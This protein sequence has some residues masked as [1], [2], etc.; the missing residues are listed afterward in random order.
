MVSIHAHGAYSFMRRCTLSCLV[1][2]ANFAIEVTDTGNAFS[3]DALYY[4]VRM[5]VLCVTEMM[6]A[7]L[8]TS[9]TNA[10]RRTGSLNPSHTPAEPK[11]YWICIGFKSHQRSPDKVCAGHNLTIGSLTLTVELAARITP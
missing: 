9:L 5:F 1:S 7:T 6:L 2:Y 11:I 8:A 3:V 4:Y 10:V